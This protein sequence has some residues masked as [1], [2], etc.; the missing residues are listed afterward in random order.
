M[1]LPTTICAFADNFLTCF[2]CP[3]C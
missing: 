2:G 3:E 1:D